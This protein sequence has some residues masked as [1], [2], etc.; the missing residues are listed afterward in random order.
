MKIF[1]NAKFDSMIDPVQ[2]YDI[3]RSSAK[4]VCW[5]IG[6]VIAIGAAITEIDN[7]SMLITSAIVDAAA[8]KGKCTDNLM[9][10]YDKLREEINE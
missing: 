10:G 6:A 7:R 1:K 4:T 5:L 2:K 8:A 9:N 3:T